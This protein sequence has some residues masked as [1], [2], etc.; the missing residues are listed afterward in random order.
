MIWYHK[1][2]ACVVG[3]HN[4]TDAP[5]AQI[6]PV[7]LGRAQLGGGGEQ[8]PPKCRHNDI[9]LQIHRHVECD[10]SKNTNPVCSPLI[11]PIYKHC[12]SKSRLPVKRKGGRGIKGVWPGQKH[13]AGFEQTWR[14]G[15]VALKC[16]QTRR[17][18]RN[19]GSSKLTATHSQTS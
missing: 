12:P 19:E 16:K 8:A 7:L 18:F 13:C 5:I 15:E 11:P 9:M 4:K 1:L 3:F 14:Y 2:A 10:S 17:V 6:L